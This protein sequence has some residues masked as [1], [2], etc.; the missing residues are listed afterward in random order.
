MLAA[1]IPKLPFLGFV[2]PVPRHVSDHV[3][4]PLHHVWCGVPVHHAPPTFVFAPVERLLCNGRWALVA[5]P[6]LPE[7]NGFLHE[8]DRRLLRLLGLESG[9][10]LAEPHG[11]FPVVVPPVPRI[12][13]EVGQQAFVSVC[14]PHTLHPLL[15]QR[16]TPTFDDG[17]GVHESVERTLRITGFDEPLDAARGVGDDDGLCEC[18]LR[19]VLD[20]FAAE[21]DDELVE[22]SGGDGVLK[23]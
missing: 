11:L 20:G 12:V 17:C 19:K 2:V 4:R 22:D 21:M 9:P 23:A 14:L 8:V 16:R 1:E 15:E 13:G 18:T 7:R 3:A 5:L 10:V 6:Q